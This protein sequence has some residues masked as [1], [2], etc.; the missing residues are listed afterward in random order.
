MQQAAVTRRLQHRMTDLWLGHTGDAGGLVSNTT[1]ADVA[2]FTP[3]P[4]P[5]AQAGRRTMAAQ[6]AAFLAAVAAAAMMWA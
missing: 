4:A 6:L 3:A 1:L 2:A 5:D